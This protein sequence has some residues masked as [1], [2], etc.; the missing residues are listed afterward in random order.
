MNELM[1]IQSRLG[2]SYGKSILITLADTKKLNTPMNRRAKELGIMVMD[3]T[4]ILAA[5]FRNRLKN[6]IMEAVPF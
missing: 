4:D 2:G 3:K 6:L 5:D 1:V